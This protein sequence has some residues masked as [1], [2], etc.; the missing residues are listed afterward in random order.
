M[1]GLVIRPSILFECYNLT[2]VIKI[3]P[4]SKP[5]ATF[6][7]IMLL[8]VMF[9][10]GL[11]GWF[12]FTSLQMVSAF[13]MLCIVPIVMLNGSNVAR[14]FILLGLICSFVTYMIVDSPESVI[15]A[16][17]KRA[18]FFQAFMTAIFTLQE[19]TLQSSTLRNI[20]NYLLNQPLKRRSAMILLGTNFLAIMMNIGSL[21]LIGSIANNKS[22]KTAN[23]QREKQIALATT[24][25]FSPTSLWSPLALPP[26]FLSSFYPDISTSMLMLYGFGISILL[27]ILSYI[28]MLFE[29]NILKSKQP[30]LFHSNH[31]PLFPTQ[32]LGSLLAIVIAIFGTIQLVVHLL[33]I[34]VST[35]VILVIPAISILW[36]LFQCRWNLHD[37]LIKPAKNIISIRL[38]QQAAET[39]I[40]VSA[41]FMSPMILALM[42]Y[43]FMALYI[44]TDTISPSLFLTI[45]FVGIIGFGA[46]GF[47][48]I[49]T[50]TI[51][52]AITGDPQNFGI[53]PLYFGLVLLTAWSLCAQLSPFTASTLVVARMFNT[54]PNNLVFKWN[55]MFFAISISIISLIILFI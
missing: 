41:A 15:W 33:E 55:G 42:P 38:P 24:R 53:D 21:V 17:V 45:L 35:A 46:I 43:D 36:L 32:S 44:N 54:T 7:G 2:V 13:V 25:G 51:A 22:V 48:P 31:K 52:I 16:G 40:L 20:G 47:S 12:F 30:E 19:A 5:V 1:D 18:M 34:K 27:L 39:S 14:L 6:L 29:L 50:I 10:Q 3:M 11:V 28:V 9:M 8:A 23:K 26:V 4:S 49:I 37:F